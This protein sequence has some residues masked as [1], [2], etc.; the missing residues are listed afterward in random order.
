L[1]PP[2]ASTKI[3]RPRAATLEERIAAMPEFVIRVAS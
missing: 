1:P 2:Q 3:N